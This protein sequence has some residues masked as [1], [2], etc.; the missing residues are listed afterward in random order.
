M[1]KKV[2]DNIA[3]V[4]MP[5][6]ATVAIVTAAIMLSSAAFFNGFPLVLG[7]TGAY[8]LDAPR[9]LKNFTINWTH[10]VF[11]SL[12][13]LPLHLNVSLWPVVLAQ[14][15]I[16][17]HLLFITLRVIEKEPVSFVSFLVLVLILTVCT[18]LPW[19]TG[20]IM[21]DAFTAV[22]ILGLFLLGFGLDRLTRRET[23]YIFVLTTGAISF[24]FSH[25]SLAC[26]LV[27]VTLALQVLLKWQDRLRVKVALLI[28]PII[29]ATSALLAANIVG[30]GQVTLSPGSPVLLLARLIEDGTAKIYLNE[31]CPEKQY[32]LCPYRA[33]LTDGWHFLWSDNAPLNK[34]GGAWQLRAEASEIIWSSLR[35]HP[36]EQLDKSLHNFFEQFVSFSTGDNLNPRSEGHSSRVI[37]N[38][39]GPSVHARFVASKQNTGKLPIATAKWLHNIVIMA[40]I[41]IVVFLFVIFVRRKESLYVSLFIL[42]LF[43]LIGNAFITGVLST[44]VSNRFQ[45][46]VIWLVI[47]YGIVGA[48]RVLRDASFPSDRL[49]STPL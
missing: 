34:A 14:G 42:I 7:D 26:G 12:F 47:F 43:G 23:V 13:I 19:V 45:S 38:A 49:A 16:L 27:I 1:S 37:Q 20:Q 33:Q 5:P 48:L 31:T 6:S 39:F 30:T 29:L 8:I 11:Y 41:P 18:N 32:A 46:R 21:A 10:P 24:H 40:A 9:F 25:F 36:A 2:A 4:H 17:A 15:L 35:A 3:P 28:G 22:V 44:V